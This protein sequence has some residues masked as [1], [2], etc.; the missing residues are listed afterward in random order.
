MSTIF[1]RGL[2]LYRRF[3]REIVFGTIIFF[4]ATISFGLGYLA[5]RE[6]NDVPIIIQK[7]QE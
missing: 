7:V 5:S 2:G 1:Y 6:M 4:T 3:R